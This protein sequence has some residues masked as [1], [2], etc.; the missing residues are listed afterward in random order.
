MKGIQITGT[1][2]STK[3][4]ASYHVTPHLATAETPFFLVYGRDPSLPFYQLLEPMQWFLG[5]PDSGHLDLESHHL[6]LTIAMKTLIKNQFKHGQK[7]TNHTQPNFKFGNRLF[8]ENKQ[9]GKWDP[10]W[11]VGYRFFHIECSRHYLHI[12]NLATGKTGPCNV[13]DVVHKPPV[14]VWNVD[15]TFGRARKFINHPVNLP[16]IPLDTTEI[17]LCETTP[18]TYNTTPF[19]FY[20]G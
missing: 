11:R 4:L 3:V 17:I 8:F 10:K 9:P 16:T 19:P 13:K 7:M 1:S 12:K 2:T 20:S 18:V 6:A 14:D 15:M 5:D